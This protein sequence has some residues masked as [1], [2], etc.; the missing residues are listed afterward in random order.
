MIFDIENSLR[1]SNFRTLRLAAKARQSIPGWL[2]LRALLKNGVDEGIT[3]DPHDT[4]AYQLFFFLPTLKDGLVPTQ[5]LQ[6]CLHASGLLN[7]FLF[8]ITE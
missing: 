2:I 8:L 3:S 6:P 4:T 1:K 5:G 7:Y